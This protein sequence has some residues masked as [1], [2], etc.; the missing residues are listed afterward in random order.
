LS[1]GDSKIG[2]EEEQEQEVKVSEVSTYIWL[3]KKKE[4]PF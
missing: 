2:D 3:A 1:P 4:T